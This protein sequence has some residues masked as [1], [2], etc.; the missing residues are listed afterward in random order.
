M[1]ESMDGFLVAA[2]CEVDL[3]PEPDLEDVQSPYLMLGPVDLEK[4]RAKVE[5]A[6]ISGLADHCEQALVS[7]SKALASPLSSF[8][9]WLRGVAGWRCVW[10]MLLLL[11]LRQG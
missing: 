6:K 7:Y 5:A 2:C 11:L 1:Q 9:C 10:V 4:M 3:T 8:P